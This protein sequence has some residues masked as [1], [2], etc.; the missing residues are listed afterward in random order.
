MLQGNIT[1]IAEFKAKLPERTAKLATLQSNGTLSV[2]CAAR[3]DRIACKQMIKLEGNI[4]MSHNTT[5]LMAKFEGKFFV[6]VCFDEPLLTR[7]RQHDQDPRIPRTDGQ[8]AG[9][10]RRD[11]RKHHPHGHLQ[12]ASSR[13]VLLRISHMDPLSDPCLQPAQTTAK[14]T[15]TVQRPQM[16]PAAVSLMVAKGSATASATAA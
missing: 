5:A 9:E 1:E 8:D 6:Q 13:S 12:L 14:K 10:T 16:Q 4:E 11:H 7:R 15:E 3:S 2:F